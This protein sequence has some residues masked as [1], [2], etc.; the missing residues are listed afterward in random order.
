MDHLSLRTVSTMHLDREGFVA[1]RHR[2]LPPPA[3]GSGPPAAVQETHGITTKPS[4]R[5]YDTIE[6]WQQDN[7]YIHGHYRPCSDSY[8]TS[9]ASL[10]YLHNQTVNVY[11]HLLG[12]IYFLAAGYSVYDEYGRGTGISSQEVF[13]LAGFFLGATLCFG[14]STCFHLFSNHSHGVYCRCLTYDFLGIVCL[15]SGSF[16]P[17]SYY[18]FLHHREW[19]LVY[20]ALVRHLGAPQE[21]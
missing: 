13:V 9:I 4:L 21:V 10:S 11:S 8:L 16:F 19:L 12:T 20:W 17:L 3:K 18:T 5:T 7:S 1:I 15:V 14:F 6:T 2:S